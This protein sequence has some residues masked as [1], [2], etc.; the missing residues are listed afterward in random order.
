MI[1]G[2]H[3]MFYSSQ[4]DKLRAFFRD[5][6]KLPFTDVGGGWLVFDLPEAEMGAHPADDS[7]AH[8]RVGRHSIS[9]YCDDIE[10][11]VA[12]LRAKGVEFTN[13]IADQGY[14]LVTQMLLP[15]G[16]VADL[17]Q[18]LYKKE[19]A[20]RPIVPA[21]KLRSALDALARPAARKKAPRKKAAKKKAATKKASAKKS[22]AKKAS[23]KKT[24]RR[25]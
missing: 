3:T 7:Q 12:D 19:T 15:G 2:V 22:S 13:E 1:R 25:K 23:K 14:G 24:A 16:V 4:A 18:P 10:K 8:S 20:P 21:A 5:T 6:L 11:T 17:Y 9:F